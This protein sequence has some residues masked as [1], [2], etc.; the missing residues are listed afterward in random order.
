MRHAG[1]TLKVCRIKKNGVYPICVKGKYVKESHACKNCM[2][3]SS[4]IIIRDQSRWGKTGWNSQSFDLCLIVHIGDNV[5]PARSGVQAVKFVINRYLNW[6]S[7]KLVII[8]YVAWE[9]WVRF[10][11]RSWGKNSNWCTL[12]KV[13]IQWK[14]L[15]IY[16]PFNF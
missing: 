11:I 1:N 4:I 10:P 16:I 6:N 5:T 13:A 15:H 12:K 8:L 9:Q 14:G 3:N 2:G 7:P